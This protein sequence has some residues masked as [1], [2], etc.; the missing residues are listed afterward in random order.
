M[1]L[2][3]L[4]LVRRRAG[5][6]E[7]RGMQ[8]GLL[9]VVV[10][11]M[12]YWGFMS[13]LLTNSFNKVGLPWL[14]LVIGMLIVSL[15]IMGLG[16]YTFNSLLFESTDTDQ[17]F[18]YPLSKLTVVLGKVSGIVVENWVI[19]LVFWLPMV[20]VYGW[21]ARPGPLF[22]L[23]ALV[24]LLIVPGIPLFVL[25]LISY[26]V[27]LVASRGRWRKI[28]QVVLSIGFMA[29]I[30]IG[31]RQAVASLLATAKI[32]VGVDLQT[33]FFDM[34]QRYYPPVGY[35]IRALVTGSWGALGM[36][37]VWNVVPFILV[38]ALIASSY[39]WIR[40]RMTA[41][42]RVTGGHLTYANS[43]AARSLYRKEL[44]RLLSSPMYV[45]NS[46]GGA[47]LTI[48]FAFLFSISTGKN[49]EA[50]R[51]MLDQMHITLT[52][53]LLVA[54]LF[55]LAMSNTTAASI[56]LEGQSLWIVQ[57]L[58]ID[59]RV[60]L[61]SK[62][63]VQVTVIPPIVALACLISVFTVWIGWDGFVIVLVPCLLFTA[64]SACV[65]LMYNLRFHRFD[66]YNDQQAVKTSASVLLT[67]GTMVVVMAVATFGYW[68]LG[69]WWT[70][71]YVAYAAVWVVVLAAA[72]VVLYRHLMTRGA[73]VFEELVG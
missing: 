12:A 1:A 34:M 46:L 16:L 58:P 41:V 47:A 13:N 69:N 9:I 55:L 67:M 50:M 19:G 52:P 35:A 73:A 33:Q 48:L 65:G 32:E 37:V 66:F 11:I 6:R 59:A 70:V 27:G 68:L 21:Y 8:A 63:L 3:Q 49:A 51:A 10:A 22:Y 53:I 26:V 24:T 56:S 15:L 31:L 40:T 64:V 42:S 71:N 4:S 57:S 25:A 29:G 17:L 5:R 72:A 39:G 36:A 14:M 28:L 18:A 7:G 38:C 44:W 45:L 43:T 20:A 23:F 61:R 60:I 2:Y 54:F 30:G 62:L